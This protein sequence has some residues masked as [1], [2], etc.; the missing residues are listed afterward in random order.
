[1]AV[2][3][4]I[5]EP[6]RQSPISSNEGI[7]SPTLSS[8]Q[9]SW[10]AAVAEALEPVAS[11]DPTI[12]D[13]P[14]RFFRP[15][16]NFYNG[17]KWIKQE[18][19][20][21]VLELPPE[22]LSAARAM[23]HPRGH[24]GVDLRPHLFDGVLKQDLLCDTG[25][26]VTAYPPDP[27]DKPVEGL[28][29]RAV[30]GAQLNCYGFKQVTVRIGRKDYHFQAIKADVQSPVIGWDFFKHYRMLNHANEKS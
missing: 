11:F 14:A 12:R 3:S 20:N 29:L 4:V 19:I 9:K 24:L 26:Q 8:F 7:Q 30:N 5:E 10:Q 2:E 13:A 21:D 18:E 15:E 28:N 22:E 25:S 23:S 1:M 17:S 16:R 6:L 27:G